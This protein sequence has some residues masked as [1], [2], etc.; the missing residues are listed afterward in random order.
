MRYIN[1]RFT[2]L[3]TYTLPWYIFGVC[4]VSILEPLDLHPNPSLIMPKSH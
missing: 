2:Y 1:S 3:L 4:G